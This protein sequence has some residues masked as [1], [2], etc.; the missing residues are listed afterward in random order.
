MKALLLLPLL[1]MLG[2]PQNPTETS[3]VNVVSFKWTRS[4]QNLQFDPSAKGPVEPVAEVN[5]S[6]KN[7]ARNARVND[8]AGARDP[9][10][11]TIDTRSANLEK[12]IQESRTPNGKPIDGFSY[13]VKVHNS[14]AKVIE[15]L[16]IEY[17]F[18]D[19]ANPANATRRQFLCGVKIKADKEKELQAFGV[20]GPSDVVRVESL[21]S[22]TEN[23]FQGKVLIN[24][25][26]Y[27]DGSTWQRKSWNAIEIKL[28]YKRA[29]STPWEPG[30]MCRGL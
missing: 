29:I 25:V 6:N 9:N 19:Q 7:I 8:P 4:R 23:L 20:L 12:A 1:V 24:R 28:G 18:I 10:E 22:K 2:F 17:D 14:S 21:G 3:P 16:F 5:S 30:E 26:E 27:A 15:A 13:L 11:T